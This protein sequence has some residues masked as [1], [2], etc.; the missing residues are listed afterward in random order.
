MPEPSSGFQD[1]AEATTGGRDRFR[2]DDHHHQPHTD[3]SYARKLWASRTDVV[4][5]SAL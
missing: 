5:P 1:G 4:N 2:W 3:L